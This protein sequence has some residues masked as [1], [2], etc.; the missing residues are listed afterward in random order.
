MHKQPTVY[1]L[2]GRQDFD[3]EKLREDIFEQVRAELLKSGGQRKDIKTIGVTAGRPGALRTVV[4]ERKISR[5][6]AALRTMK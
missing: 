2:L 3:P 4:V 6:P 1:S 5:R